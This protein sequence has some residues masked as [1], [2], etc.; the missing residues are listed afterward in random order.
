MSCQSVSQ[1]VM[2]G[3]GRIMAA[4]RARGT[5]LQRTTGSL[6]RAVASGWLW[7]GFQ[8]GHHPLSLWLMDGGR[9]LGDV[10]P[11]QVDNGWKIFGVLTDK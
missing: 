6:Q 11:P 4:R 1:K 7:D 3:M 10:Y 2:L 9:L 8:A 5:A